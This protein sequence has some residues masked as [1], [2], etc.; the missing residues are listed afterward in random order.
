MKNVCLML[1]IF[2]VFLSCS[3]TYAVTIPDANLAA[4]VREALDLGPTDPIPQKELEELEQLITSQKSISD[5]TGLEKATG[6]KVLYLGRNRISDLTPLT[7]LTQLTELYLLYN[8][9]SDITPLAKL[10]QL[11]SLSLNR[12][13][14]SDITPLANLTQIKSLRL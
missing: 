10:T 1:T 3:F 14:I 2:I 8:Q 6:L 11:T 4:V 5:L 9:I 7:K 13:Q 12:N